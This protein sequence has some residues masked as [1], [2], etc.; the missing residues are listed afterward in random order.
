MDQQLG[1]F[2]KVF[3]TK[4]STENVES[5]KSTFKSATY[6]RFFTWIRALTIE[7]A[8]DRA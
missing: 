5:L 6:R 8:K 1:E 3:S 2:L 4:L 7:L